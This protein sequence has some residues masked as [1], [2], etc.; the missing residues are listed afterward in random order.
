MIMI[1]VKQQ[2]FSGLLLLLFGT[3]AAWCYF[4]GACQPTPYNDHPIISL[5]SLLMMHGDI[6]LG[7]VASKPTQSRMTPN[8]FDEQFLSEKRVAPFRW[9]AAQ[10]AF[11]MLKLRNGLHRLRGQQPK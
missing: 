6:P 2:T 5:R 3:L 10:V 7:Q 8:H 4:V 11:L 1:S 9:T